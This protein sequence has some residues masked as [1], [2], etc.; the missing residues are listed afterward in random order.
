[1]IRTFRFTKFEPSIADVGTERGWKI[2]TCKP[3]TP[4]TKRLPL[5][6]ERLENNP[7]L[8]GNVDFCQASLNFESSDRQEN[9]LG[10]LSL[11]LF[12][13][14]KV[15]RFFAGRKSFT[16]TPG[17]LIT[18]RQVAGHHGSQDRVQKHSSG[19]SR[20]KNH[21]KWQTGYRSKS[22]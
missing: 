17:W 8:Q 7:F 3:Y 22:P 12:H 10:G 2:G 1:M 14:Q 5:K 20:P 6:N 4:K 19:T 21:I 15:C 18:Q 9:M 11:A 16:R 13:D